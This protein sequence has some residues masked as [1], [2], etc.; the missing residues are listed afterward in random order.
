MKP[1]SVDEQLALLSPEDDWRPDTT[2]AMAQFRKLRDGGSRQGV[3]HRVWATAA[4]MAVCACLLAF[5]RLWKSGESA[6]AVRVLKDGQRVPDFHLQD[7][8]GADLRLSD[9]KGRAV[10]LNFWATWC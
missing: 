3:R 2:R 5:P 1:E 7:S 8:A 9:Y 4:A 10:L 6:A